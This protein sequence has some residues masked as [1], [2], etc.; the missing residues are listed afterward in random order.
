MRFTK[1]HGLGNDFL[2][3]LDL[4]DTRPVSSEL[5]R[6]VCDRHRGVGADGVLRVT[7]GRPGCDVT[8]HLLNADGSRAEMSGNGISCLVQAVRHAK[9]VRSSQVIVATDAGPRRV[10]AAGSGDWRVDRM[11]VDMGPAKVLDDDT[12]WLGVPA[13]AAARVDVGNPHLVLH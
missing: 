2:V 3:M 10:A 7:K 12:D 5:A 9:L 11:T 4:D 13:N 1:H 8:M 6:A